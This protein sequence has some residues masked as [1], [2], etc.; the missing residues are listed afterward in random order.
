MFFYLSK[1]VYLF[2]SPALWIIVLLIWR[3]LSKSQT[4]KKRLMI[5]IICLVFFFGNEVIYNG[6]VRWWQSK[7]VVLPVNAHYDAGILLG[8]LGSFDKNRIGFLNSACDRLIETCILYKQGTIDK[9]IISGGSVY[10]NE[11]KEAPFLQRK[12][13]ELGIPAKDV[14]IESQSRTTF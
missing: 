14:F 7:P 4:T 5:T 6:L 10:K 3:F 2:L 13:L 12:I 9:I 8:G 11:P 1:L